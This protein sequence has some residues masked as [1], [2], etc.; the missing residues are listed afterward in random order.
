M[1]Q[2]RDLL[3]SPAYLSHGEI[4]DSLDCAVRTLSEHLINTVSL[5]QKNALIQC[6]SPHNK[7]CPCNDHIPY[8]AIV[9]EKPG[10]DNTG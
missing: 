9:S 8:E 2:R 10:S 3:D 4:R 6:R 7:R 5:F 1:L